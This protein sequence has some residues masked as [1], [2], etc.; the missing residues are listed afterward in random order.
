MK[1]CD[2]I[3]LFFS[4]TISSAFAQ[5]YTGKEIMLLNEESRKSVTETADVYITMTDAQGNIRKRKLKLLIDDGDKAARKS[6]VE[7]VEPQDVKG[8]RVL[9]LEKSNAEQDPDRWIYLPAL[10]KVRRIAGADQTQSFVGTD[11][12]YEDMSITD[13]V[14]GV[15]HH[16]YTILREETI[17]DNSGVDRRC[18]VI[19]AVPTTKKQI[20]QGL[21]GKRVIWVEQQHFTAVQEHYFNKGGQLFKIRTS[22]DIT[23]FS[24]A[25]GSTEWRPNLFSMKNLITGHSTDVRFEQV[26]DQPIDAKIFTRRFLEIG[27]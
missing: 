26:L 11:F 21:Y 4:A 15:Q 27:L 16:R 10:R 14:V 20:D 19:E 24:A 3:A 1:R 8:T 7:F 9:S 18:W 6:Y 23:A 25:G 13:G 2:F 12:T 22:S 17:K 5:D